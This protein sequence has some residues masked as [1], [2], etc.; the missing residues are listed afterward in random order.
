MEGS[1]IYQ[2]PRF[3]LGY[4]ESSRSSQLSVNGPT[5]IVTV[6]GSVDRERF[7]VE[8]GELVGGF[9][10]DRWIKIRT[11][12]SEKSLAYYR[13]TAVRNDASF[14]PSEGGGDGLGGTNIAEGVY[15]I[16][17]DSYGNDTLWFGL[18]TNGASKIY[19]YVAYWQED[20]IYD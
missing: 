6:G 17:T 5:N 2:A 1:S 19:Y 18:D 4:S 11:L 15:R 9:A 10:N 3:E 20:T 14:N 7:V 16:T 13:V 12:S 8:T